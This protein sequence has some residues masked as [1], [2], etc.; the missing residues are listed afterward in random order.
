MWC[1]WNFFRL[2]LI[3]NISMLFF[4]SSALLKKAKDESKHSENWHPLQRNE[5]EICP[6]F[7]KSPMYDVTST[8]SDQ[9]TNPSLLHEINLL[10]QFRTDSHQPPPQALRFL[11]GS[12]ESETSD[13]WWTARNHGKG[14][15]GRRSPLFPSR[16][17]LRAHFHQKR[18]VWVRGRTHT[19]LYT[20]IRC[21][22]GKTCPNLVPR[23]L[24]YLSLRRERT[25][26]RSWPCAHPRIGHI[27]E[28]P[29]GWTVY[30]IMWYEQSFCPWNN[31]HSMMVV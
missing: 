23:V 6:P 7:W 2:N 16:L 9:W 13:W 31:S 12:G 27:R 3:A 10:A 29:P 5:Q 22:S 11:H 1:F 15:E 20:L 28:Y 8:G 24:S 21:F 18:D 30:I 25:W 26:E 14:T 17:P 4:K 19:K